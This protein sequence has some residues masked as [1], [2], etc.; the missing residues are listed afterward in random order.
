[1]ARTKGAKGLRSQSARVIAAK[2]GIEPLLEVIKCGKMLLEQEEYDKAANAFSKALPY[3]HQ[4]QGTVTIAQDDENPITININTKAKK[5][6]G[7]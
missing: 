1:M 4:T 3:L 2:A 5:K 6:D 7:D